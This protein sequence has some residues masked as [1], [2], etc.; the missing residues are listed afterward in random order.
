MNEPRLNDLYQFGMAGSDRIDGRRAPRTQTHLKQG[1]YA[2]RFSATMGRW[3]RLSWKSTC[4]VNRSPGLPTTSV[5]GLAPSEPRLLRAKE[6]SQHSITQ[7]ARDT[8]TGESFW[9]ESDHRGQVDSHGASRAMRRDR[10]SETSRDTRT[11]A[12]SGDRTQKGRRLW[13]PAFRITLR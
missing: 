11:V 12:T 6:R 4:S 10:H 7:A 1:R 2:T 13:T 5:C 3:L 9:L 8:E